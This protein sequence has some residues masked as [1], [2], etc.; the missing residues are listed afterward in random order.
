MLRA[1]DVSVGKAFFKANGR[2]A[3]HNE[4]VGQI[5]VI[6]DNATKRIVGVTMVGATS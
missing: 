5:N 3:T 6:R 4:T 2:S 1:L